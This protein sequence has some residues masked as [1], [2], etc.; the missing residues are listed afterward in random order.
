MDKQ[1][2]GYKKLKALLREIPSVKLRDLL[3][4]VYEL[5]ITL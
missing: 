5:L 2:K 3:V 4:L 1:N